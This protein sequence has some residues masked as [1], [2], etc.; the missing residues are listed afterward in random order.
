M[1]KTLA[2]KLFLLGAVLTALLFQVSDS[3]SQCATYTITDVSCNGGSDGSV[4]ITINIGSAPYN[5]SIFTST[6]SQSFNN[7]ASNSH[8]FTGL[9]AEPNLLIV[10]Q[11]WNGTK[12]VYC[13]PITTA[14]N[15]PTAIS[16]TGT[17][18]DVSCNG[19]NTGS[20]SLSVSGGTPGYTYLWSNG[21][22]TSNLSNLTAGSY[23]VTVTDSKNCTYD[24]TFTISEPNAISVTPTI[25]NVLCNG[26]NNG[27]INL[28]VSGGSAPYNYSWSTG[29]STQNISGLPAGS[30]TVTITDNN[31]CS[32]SNTYT[33]TQPAAA[34]SIS[35][36]QTN[37][38]CNGGSN[39]A[40]NITVN[41]G[42][43]PY[44]YS[45]NNGSTSQ[46]I[47]GLNAGSYTVTVTDNNGCTQNTSFTITEPAGA[48]LTG[49][50]TNI[51]CNGNT[52]GAIGLSVSGGTSPYT[53]LWNTGATT[54]NLSGL[55]SGT[56]SVTVTDQLGCTKNASYT[57]T[58]PALLTVSGSKTDGS[59]T[60]I[61]NGSITLSVSGGT[62]PYTYLW[63]TGATTQN[64][65]GLAAGTYSVTVTD[66]NGCKQNASF[67]ITQPSVMTITNSNTNV[68]CFGGNN[69]AIDLTVSGGTTPYSYSWSN[70]ATTQDIT[71]L[72]AGSYSVTIT[73]NSGCSQNN[74]Y[75]ITQPAASLSVS[76]TTTD[77]SCNGGNT[78]AINIAVSGGTSPYSYSWSNGST[79]QNLSGLTSG[80]Y[81]VTVTDSKGCIKNA[82]FTIN[83]PTAISVTG[84]TTDVSCNG[85]NNGAVNLSVSGGTAPYTY[86][87]SNGASSQNISG[88]TAGS[89]SVTVTDSKGCTKNASSTI[90]QPA[91]ALAVSGT[92][93]DATCTGVNNGSINLSVNGGTSPYSYSWSNGAATQNISGLAAGS[94][95]VTV[96][97]T[98]GCTQNSSFTI[99]Q[100]AI[101]TVSNSN[102]NV[103]CFGG[104]TGAIDLTVSGGTSPYSYSWS[105]SATSQDIS[106]L[107]AGSYSVTITDNNGCSQNSSYSI[108]QPSAAL[109]VSG[110]TTNESCNGGN[111]GAITLSVSGGTTPYSFLWNNGSTSQNLS[112]LT[113]GSYSVT[114]TDGNGC[115]K[116]ASFTIT[117]PAAMS[118]TGT[119][120]DVS[121]N[122]G[123]NGAINLTVSGGTSPYTY[124]WNNGANTQNISGLAAGSYS[125]IITDAT[126]CIQN[127]SFTIAEPAAISA[128]GTTTDVV[129]N[130]GNTGVINLIVNGGTSPYTYS[131]SNGATSQNI[132]G[133]AA[134]SYSVTI[135]DAKSCTQNASFTIAEPTA[136]SATGTTTDVS[137]N[138]GNDGLINLSVSGGTAPY[139]YSWNTGANTQNISSLTQGSYSVTVTDANGCTKNAS[140][141]INQPNA[142]TATGTTTNI[143]CFGGNNGDINLSVSGG[144][145]S[146]TFAWSN[147][148]TSQNIS[149]LTAGT[150][151]VTI[152]DNN[153]CSVNSSF[154]ITQPAAALSA[155]GT[156]SDASC[157]GVN[158]GSITL[159]VNGGT[160]P[161]SYLWSNGATTQNL[162]G[163]SAGSYSVTVT[164]NNG[165]TQAA[166][167]TI[168]QPSVM[169]L[170]NTN[171][172]VSCF[173]GNNGAIDLS[174]SGG[175][176][177]YSYSWSNSMTTQDISTLTAGSYSVTV[178]DNNG[179]SQN[180]S[181]TINQPAAAL[182][183]SGTTT[184]ELCSGG[185]TGSINLTVNGGTSPY[186]YSW[187]TGDNTSSISNLLAGS[188]SVTVT[189]GDGCSQNASFTVSE[190]TPISVS[191]TTTDVS[192]NGGNTGAIN[193]TV[194]GGTPSYNYLWSNGDNTQ[195]I[196]GLTAGSYSVTITDIDGCSQ[197]ASFSI[198]EPA[199]ISITG[200]TTDVTCNGGNNGDI[201]LLVSGGASPY[202]FLWSNGATSQNI[203]TLT[204]GSYSVTV[205]DKNGCTK[206]TT[207]NISEPSAIAVTANITDVSC[208]GGNTGAINVSVS[209]G[210]SPYTYSWN[211]GGNTPTISSL[212]IGSY[213]LTIFDNAGCQIDTTFA[214]NQATTISIASTTTNV[215]CNGGSNGA[216]DI[217][218]SGGTGGYTFAWSNGASTEDISSLTAAN[219]SVTVNDGNG[220]NQ[221]ASFT[222]SEPAPI[223]ITATTT[224]VL[225]NGGNNGAINLTVTG[226]ITPYSFSWDN[227]STTQNLSNITA[228][229]YSIIVT[230]SN[231]CTKTDNYTINEP[232]PISI[233][234]KV[235]D[236]NCNGANSGAI[237]IT[238]SG[239]TGSYIYSWSNS[240]TNEDLTS[241]SA[242]T[243]SVTVTDANNCTQTASYTVNQPS[244]MTI[245]GTVVNAMCTGVSDGVIYITNQVSGGQAPYSYSWN[246]GATTDS[247]YNLSDGTYTVTVTDANGCSQ[248][249]SFDITST[250]G[251]SIVINKSDPSCFGYNNGY[252]DTIIVS[253]GL[254]PYK[255]SYNGSPFIT[256][257]AKT[258]VTA[259]TDTITIKDANGCLVDTIVTFTEPAKLVLSA[260]FNSPICLNGNQGTVHLSAVGGTMGPGY[261][262]SSDNFNYVINDSVYSGLAPGNYMYY[263][264]DINGCIDSTIATLAAFPSVNMSK[265]N[266]TVINLSCNGVNTG[267]ID[268]SNITGGT[269]PFIFTLDGDPSTQQSDSSYKHLDANLHTITI[270]DANQCNYDT[271][272]VISSPPLIGSNVAPTKLASC[273]K[274]DGE[275]QL[276]SISGGVPGYKYSFDNGPKTT[277]TGGTVTFSNLVAGGHTLTVFDSSIPGC[278]RTTDID[279]STKPGPTPFIRIDSVQCYHGKDGIISVDSLQGGVPLFDINLYSIHSAFSTTHSGVNSLTGTKF[280]GLSSD[281]FAI[282]TT[283]GDGC[284]HPVI[285]YYLFNGVDYDTIL[286]PKMYVGQ[287]DTINFN[288]HTTDTD[289]HMDIGT[290]LFTH[291][292]GATYPYTYA[293][294]TM[295]ASFKPVVNDSAKI[296]GLDVGN[297]TAYVKDNH[298][299]L[300]KVKFNIS[301]G[302][303]IPNL[304]S[305]NGDGHNDYFEIIALPEGSDLRIFNKWGSRVYY[306]KNYD[307]SWNGNNDPDGVYYYELILPSKKLYK[308]WIEILR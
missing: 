179:C 32:Q 157:T 225:C 34:L 217:T 93:T 181:Y 254:S 202:T 261:L 60:G 252:I 297:F 169:T 144:T 192:C 63:N 286:S 282:V 38:T 131:W 85:G 172:D 279:L 147:G 215:S 167:F 171:T 258:K 16:S 5:F 127:A 207:I 10:T 214:V 303:F 271:S 124:T 300:Y 18:T 175:T 229:N 50:V 116:N 231:N 280:N 235:T 74:T 249:A 2:K 187:S 304:I 49:T 113:A 66:N 239:G 151:S 110:T 233:T 106:G 299:C 137:C 129:C 1:M 189:D 64:L 268:L 138:G 47:S 218:V 58:E 301:V 212:A 30:Y 203:S 241:L 132:S 292:T 186:N 15:E 204:A 99:S 242:G 248:N 45:W 84:T 3:Y 256:S 296:N 67:S 180:N 136:I 277:Y 143:S 51:T 240:S 13:P 89:Y 200:T 37:V 68:S 198:I 77:E 111:T 146:Y 287:P 307:N 209:G 152:T 104:N 9:A 224:D 223:S 65:S 28:S 148:A 56:Y 142:I 199:V 153:G 92:K 61:N 269:R 17:T 250:P 154:T 216:I 22:S 39:G 161:Y 120:T 83:Q 164:D 257:S 123:N 78:G 36:S 59:C 168:N 205:T 298:Q 80:S 105:N 26:G 230:D 293:M 273:N 166:S 188:Y 264:R 134:G 91:A 86:L 184:D 75:S 76:G 48:S 90:N 100:P 255:F 96:T 27:S 197:N 222:I 283:D 44:T 82:S 156:A 40:I 102:T 41:G 133:L 25:T 35:G 259:G 162:T 79:S 141:T 272:I 115:T 12:Y 14:I 23:D 260:T 213:S 290:A 70:S 11:Y 265:V 139:T 210:T 114:V 194:N 126:G 305:P 69:G 238:V 140:F 135:T 306:N 62:A 190:P 253:G 103:S 232:S 119:T 274:A 177:P 262:Y 234:A 267:E 244:G 251:F 43:A 130:G 94:Y 20:I 4:K 201:S 42:T 263:V 208:N 81:S 219:Y 29:A 247:I 270:T 266:A 97:D 122:G 71:G 24:T 295:A 145:G 226:G 19:G 183:I 193:L 246:N 87:W 291:F 196:T 101:M 211:T 31:L 176:S 163:L 281:T 284:I 108:T 178:T 8:T 21:V 54:Q 206:D 95:S 285:E 158:N 52:D 33:I 227:G 278:S 243:Y 72:T 118:V 128:T 228:G 109:S 6:G 107:T 289:R 221:N 121:C 98:K 46:N 276:T 294:D 182:T 117:E 55:A 125:V 88:L 308:G 302:M 237:D 165:C 150:Y 185:N 149:G 160:T 170:S 159:T 195:N 7:S 73:D 112:N 53:Y 288:V 275:I 191:G 57:V 155:S 245:N 173:G 174:V 236:E 220:C